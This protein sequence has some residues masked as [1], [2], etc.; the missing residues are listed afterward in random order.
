MNNADLTTSN[1]LLA[2]AV[3]L[4]LATC[5]GILTAPIRSYALRAGLVEAPGIRS[6]HAQPTPIGGG[7]A[8]VVPI[9]VAWFITAILSDDDALLAIACS[10]LALACIGF[11]DDR[12]RL[13]PMLRLSA[14]C[15]AA[16]AVCFIAM[17]PPDGSGG[18]A[19]VVRVLAV[20]AI[21][22][23]SNLF[24][25]MDGLDG[26]ATSESLFVV[27]GG[28]AVAILTGA[29]SATIVAMAA[30]AGGLGGFLPWNAPKAR[31]FMGDAGS[32]WLGFVL[33]SLALLEAG[34]QPGALQ[35][36]LIFPALFV[37]DAT[38]C[39]CRRGLRGEN[40]IKAHRAHAYQNLSRILGSHAKVVA[41]FALGNLCLV[42]AAWAC[43]QF[44][45]MAWWVTGA[46]YSVLA[47]LAVA[48]R[49]GVHGVA[50]TAPDRGSRC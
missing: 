29:G 4:M 46:T 40:V 9:T 50:D 14:Q 32:T 35:A 31:I 47:V 36:W 13:P 33:A 45:G 2:A 8:F 38:V 25:F 7:L 39:L 37:T 18:D 49:S 16:A 41:I 10:G 3:A 42:P 19:A 1:A 11:E 23:S 34:R 5:V 17:H 20:L 22:W 21:A 28:L 15:V 12:R 6:S 24:N 30:L 26:L 48:A 43:I 27:L 44:P